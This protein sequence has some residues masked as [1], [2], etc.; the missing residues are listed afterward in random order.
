MR[1][2][3]LALLTTLWATAPFAASLESLNMGRAFRDLK[4]TLHPRARPFCRSPQS[5]PR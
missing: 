3:L 4:K 5:R 1:S 2:F